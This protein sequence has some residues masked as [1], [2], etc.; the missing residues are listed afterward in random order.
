MG[1]RVSRIG[2]LWG[3]WLGGSVL[4]LG[5]CGDGPNRAESWPELPGAGPPTA[6]VPS[7]PGSPSERPE[8]GRA[9]DRGAMLGFTPRA[10]LALFD[11]ATGAVVASA[12]CAGGALERDLAFDH[13][14]E[15]ALV[16]ETDAEGSSSEIW[17]YPLRVDPAGRPALGTRE[18]RASSEGV[19]RIWPAPGGLVVFEPSPGPRWRLLRDDGEAVATVLAPLPLS[20]WGREHAAGAELGA[21]GLTPDGAATPLAVAS[22]W[23]SDDAVDTFSLEPLSA[24]AA[25]SAGAWRMAPLPPDL[26]VACMAARREPGWCPDASALV[27]VGTR[28]HQLEFRLLGGQAEPPSAA[29]ALPEGFGHVTQV[30]VMPGLEPGGELRV[31]VLAAEPTSLLVAAFAP[32]LELVD[33]ASLALAGKLELDERFFARALLAV[34][35][36]RLLAATSTGVHAVT[37]RQTVE[38]DRRGGHLGLELDPRF[39]GSALR[40]PLDGPALRIQ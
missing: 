26:R 25:P 12:G 21:L 4:L 31:A 33:A 1:I 17:S 32:G 5:G 10:E 37:V 23:L 34:G 14:H 19:G 35:G 29:L 18:H 30:V 2:G 40:G 36:R 15:R 38:L 8:A 7:E 9:A 24:R 28:A 27:L 20:A 22:A 3:L 13:R 16:L 11:S 39:D 6:A